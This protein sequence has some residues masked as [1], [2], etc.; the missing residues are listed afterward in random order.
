VEL[1]L[2]FCSTY[3]VYMSGTQAVDCSN[4]SVIFFVAMDHFYRD[5]TICLSMPLFM[6]R[7]L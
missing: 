5:V 3:I 6:D 7:S 4:N 2:P 1:C